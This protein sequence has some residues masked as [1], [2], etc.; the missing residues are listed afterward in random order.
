MTGHV[1]LFSVLFLPLGCW[2]Q[3]F[4]PHGK[5][6]L[7]SLRASALPFPCHSLWVLLAIF[8]SGERWYFVFFQTGGLHND[9]ISSAIHLI[10]SRELTSR[11]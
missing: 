6:L 9:E 4:R 1:L 2:I 10:T 3:E 7:E 8:L 11:Y 5:T